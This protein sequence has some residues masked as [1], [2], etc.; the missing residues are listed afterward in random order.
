MKAIS[1]AL[2]TDLAFVERVQWL[3]DEA[4]R[5]GHPGAALVVELRL[6]AQVRNPP[7]RL[8]APTWKSM[9]VRWDSPDVE[10]V[11]VHQG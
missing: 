1:E 4:R 9:P 10:L 7:W 5:G 3:R 11:R 2:Q 8:A 6:A